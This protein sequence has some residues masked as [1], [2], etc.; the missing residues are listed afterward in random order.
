[1]GRAAIAGTVPTPLQRGKSRSEAETMG[2]RCAAAG[3][4]RISTLRSCTVVQYP[5]PANGPEKQDLDPFPSTGQIVPYFEKNAGTAGRGAAAPRATPCTGWLFGTAAVRSA[6]PIVTQNPAKK[7]I[8]P[9]AFARRSATRFRRL[10]GKNRE[11]AG[12]P[13]PDG[14]SPVLQVVCWNGRFAPIPVAAIET[15]ALP[16]AERKSAVGIGW[17]RRPRGA[18]GAFRALTG[19]DI[20]DKNQY[21]TKKSEV[22]GNF[23]DFSERSAPPFG[24]AQ[25]RL[26][27]LRSGQAFD[28]RRTGTA[29]IPLASRKAS[30]HGS[31]PTRHFD[32]SGAAS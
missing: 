12:F 25:G 26:L 31:N 4:C 19:T 7:D 21:V 30:T 8:I 5:I 32:R 22:M 14:A 10:G 16:W 18:P 29:Q 6:L 3:C 24:F 20:G 17:K 2:V 11:L 23:L 13:D 1:M 28:T 15:A 9:C 27:Q